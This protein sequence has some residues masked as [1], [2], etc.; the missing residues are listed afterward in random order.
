MQSPFVYSVYTSK[1]FSDSG[2]AALF[3]TSFLFS[4]LSALFVGPL[5]DRYGRK[6]A[7][8]LF[9]VL[10]SLSSLT[11]ILDSIWTLALGRALAGVSAT[12][13]STVFEMWL[14]TEHQRHG[15]GHA[16][17][18]LQS[19]HGA[20]STTNGFVAI[21]AGITSQFLVRSFESDTAPFMASIVCL[22]ALFFFISKHWVSACFPVQNKSQ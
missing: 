15:F 18:A 2:I 3:A 13:L 16:E 6:R 19:I 14:L 17:E 9:C 7:C 5:A 4:G 10:F 12:L 11:V 20:M 1:G 8:L 21:A 22:V